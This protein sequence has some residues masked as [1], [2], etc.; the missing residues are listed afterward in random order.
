MAILLKNHGKL[1]IAIISL[2][3]LFLGY[4]YFNSFYASVLTESAIYYEYTDGVKAEAVIIRNEETVTVEQSGTLHFNV[5]DGEKIAKDG[6]IANIYDS[7]AA[8]VAATEISSLEERIALI[9]EL[10]IYNDITAIDLKVLNARIDTALNEFIVQGADGNFEGCDYSLETLLT[11][12]TRKQVVMGEK[13]DFA[14]LKASLN[15]QITSLKAQAS[16]PKDSIK[17]E[18]AGYFVSNVDGFE[19]VYK[20]EDISLFTPEYL[21]N[22]KPA[23]VDSKAVG[24]IVHDYKWYIASVIPVSDSMFYKIGDRVTLETESISNPKITVTVEKINLSAD[25]DDATIIFSSN[26]MSKDVASMRNSK[27]TIIKNEYKGLKISNKALRVVNGETGVFVVSGIQAK[28]VKVDV[29]YQDDEYAICE[30]NVSDSD[31][32]RLYDEIIVKGK[33]LY[34]GKIIY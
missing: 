6:I 22:A 12:M 3:V 28:F 9:E 7:E 17:S 20:T 24:K 29:I 32:L 1:K 4:Q 34:D 26:Q 19:Q 2:L 30:L 27:I 11:L 33:N 16:K 10:E 18:L 5:A 23:E 25:G 8:S 14:A 21:K 13:T 15:E 31:K